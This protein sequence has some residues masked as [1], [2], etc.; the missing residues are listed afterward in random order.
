MSTI[1]WDSYLI[2]TNIWS[3][4]ED[5]VLGYTLFQIPAE[6]LFFFVIQTYGVCVFY[7]CFTK[8][9]F[10][11]VFLPLTHQ[12]SARRLVGRLGQ[13]VFLCGIL[14]SYFMVKR[15]AEGTYLGL[16]FIWALPFVLLLWCVRFRAC[17]LGKKAN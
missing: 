3:Y 14:Y 10:Y 5:A 6:E 2:H 11:P 1:P 15:G 17:E 13:L 16:I 4:P 9:A 7:I 8:P 12:I